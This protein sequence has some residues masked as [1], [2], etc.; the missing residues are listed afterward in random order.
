MNTS[1]N[2][3]LTGSTL[4]DVIHGYAGNDLINGYEG[5]DTLYGDTGNDWL[6]GGAGN[7]TFIGGTGDDTFVLDTSLDS[8][9]EYSG[10]GYDTILVSFDY[11]I[12]N[13]PYVEILRVIGSNGVSITG[14]AEDNF[15]TGNTGNDV[16]TGGAGA[17]AFGFAANQ[18]VDRIT[19]FSIL[20]GDDIRIDSGVNGITTS[21]QALAHVYTDVNGYAV[22]DL[23]SGNSVSLVGVSASSLH[24][25]DFVI[26]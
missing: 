6:F 25:S 14:N 11:S 17:D 22:I 8:V 24:A 26:W 10:E 1:G 21:T 16:L 19:D 9:V 23:G 15:L 13:L 2:D 18:G 12:I 5:N 3:T 20:Q 7:D 4:A